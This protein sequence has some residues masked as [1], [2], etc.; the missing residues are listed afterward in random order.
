MDGTQSA[1][2]PFVH[3]HRVRRDD[4]CNIQSLGSACCPSPLSF[5]LPGSDDEQSH[6]CGHMAD[7]AIV[8]QSRR[9]P[10]SIID[11]LIPHYGF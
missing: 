10:E 8:P 1:D 9:W 7:I 4:Q 11:D 2:L 3:L 6:C 5:D